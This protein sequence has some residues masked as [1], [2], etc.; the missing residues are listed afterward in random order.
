M[1]PSRN[2]PSFPTMRH[3]KA[4]TQLQ[5]HLIKNVK[6]VLF[7]LF[8]TLLILED[9]HESY[10][11][12]LAK[13]H[14]Y[15]SDNGLKCSFSEFREAYFR[16]VDQI[17]EETAS[18]LKEPHFKEYLVRTL[19]PINLD[20]SE[21]ETF[22]L[23]AIREF[24]RE[25]KR[26][27]R[28]DPEAIKVLQF[29]SG[30]YKT[31]LISNLTFSECARELLEEFELSDF[32][33]TIIV[34]GEVNLRKPHPEIFKL[35]LNDLGVNPSQAI[36]VGDNLETDISGSRKAGMIPIHIQRKTPKNSNIKSYRTITKLKQLLPIFN[37]QVE[38]QPNDQISIL[39]ESDTN[40]LCRL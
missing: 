19:S 16:A 9:E 1:L 3:L 23:G 34:S 36:F 11:Q 37:E 28:I 21:N 39:K 13:M 4:K 24:C 8:D 22:V 38:Y 17:Y 18:S 35:A 29:I 7:D 2:S 20:T 33:D 5:L 26:Y 14:N 15:L 12:S 25:F 32:F 27:V 30:K 10:V 31:G 40:V 6:A